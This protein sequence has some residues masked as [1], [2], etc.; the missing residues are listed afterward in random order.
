MS[1]GR[2]TLERT[3]YH[4]AGHAVMHCLL[5]VPFRRV[6][7]RRGVGS[8]GRI[9]PLRECEASSLRDAVR[10]ILCLYA[11]TWATKIRTGR[12]DGFWDA[13]GSD[14]SKAESIALDRGCDEDDLGKLWDKTPRVLRQH[15]PAVEAIAK[16]LL[17]HGEMSGKRVRQIVRTL[18]ARPGSAGRRSGG[19]LLGY[20][21]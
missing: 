19:R 3:A 11:G 5:H 4:E 17:K 21:L 20:L 12:H 6:S 8:V 15:W 2:R 18:A 13:A 16:E 1:T 14:W 9:I 10:L 7:V